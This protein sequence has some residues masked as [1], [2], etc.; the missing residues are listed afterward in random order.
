MSTFVHCAVFG[1]WEKTDTA[2]V[3]GVVRAVSLYQNM[4]QIT[5]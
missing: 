1:V 5:N 4:E 3:I 2:A